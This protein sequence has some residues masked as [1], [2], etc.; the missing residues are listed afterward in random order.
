MWQPAGK[1]PHLPL[2]QRAFGSEGF[3]LCIVFKLKQSKKTY[4]I[5]IGSTNNLKRRLSQHNADK[6]RSTKG[7]DS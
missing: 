3:W 2:A 5:Y 4:E 1:V 7:K 6:S